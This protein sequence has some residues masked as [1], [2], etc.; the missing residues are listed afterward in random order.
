MTISRASRT[1]KVSYKPGQPKSRGWI[2]TES[3]KPFGAGPSG[4]R[5]RKDAPR[6]HYTIL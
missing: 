4:P 2:K 6:M 1:G 3:D 5:K